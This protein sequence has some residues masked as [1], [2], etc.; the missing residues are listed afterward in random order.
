M[1]KPLSIIVA[2]EQRG[3]IGINNRLP[4][5]I[6]KDA[7]FF[8]NKTIHTS[9]PEKINAVI[10]GR[11]TWDSLPHAPLRERLNIVISTTVINIGIDDSAVQRSGDAVGG[12]V[13]G[14][15]CI[16][17]EVT[18]NPIYFPTLEQAVK[19]CD[20]C[21]AVESM[22]VIGG[23]QLYSYCMRHMLE[24][25]DVV[26]WTLVKR[27]VVGCDC[28]FEPPAEF[29]RDFRITCLEDERIAGVNSVGDDRIF[30]N[31]MTENEVEGEI[32]IVRYERKDDW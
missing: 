28:F 14:S 27:V 30:W 25:L 20:E 19:H 24:R 29:F 23:G 5:K 3:G 4:W 18:Q 16:E 13:G 6:P 11:K 2:T 12:G 32:T 17:K 26:Y 31:G 22:F 15:S 21:L 10:M 9:S 7:Q 1:P 8:R